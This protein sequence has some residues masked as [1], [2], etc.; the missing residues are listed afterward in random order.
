MENGGDV[1]TQSFHHPLIPLH[2]IL[3]FFSDASSSWALAGSQGDVSHVYH[4]LW[5]LTSN[6]LGLDLPILW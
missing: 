6:T 1:G 3:K 4:F 2:P 5:P